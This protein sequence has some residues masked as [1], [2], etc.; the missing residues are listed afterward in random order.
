MY[1]SVPDLSQPFD[2]NLFCHLSLVIV[3]QYH[4]SRNFCLWKSLYLQ[5]TEC[6]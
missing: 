5:S 2:R 4:G 6:C 1:S 3:F